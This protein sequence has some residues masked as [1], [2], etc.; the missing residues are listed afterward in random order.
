MARPAASPRYARVAL[1]AAAAER[2]EAHL[3]RADAWLAE[4]GARAFE[5]Q[6]L[7]ALAELARAAGEGDAHDRLRCEALHLY[8]E[9]GATGHAKRLAAELAVDLRVAQ[10]EDTRFAVA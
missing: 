9:M 3:A 4:T 7:E 5:P 6:I 2:A 8:R 10:R 1:L